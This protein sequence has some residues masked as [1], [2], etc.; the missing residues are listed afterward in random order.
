M[1]L[2]PLRLSVALVVLGVAGLSSFCWFVW[3]PLGL[4]PVS[5]ASLAAGSLVD[6]EKLNGKPDSPAHGT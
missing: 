5:V 6:W 3:P 2:T 1:A 4:L